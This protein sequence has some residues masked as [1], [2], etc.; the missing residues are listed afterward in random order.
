LTVALALVSLTAHA[1]QPAAAH[2]AA[3]TRYCTT[4]HNAKLKVAG[5]VLNPAQAATP[6][7]DAETWEKV[8][9][10]LRSG[11]MPPAGSSRPDAATYAATAAFLEAGLDRAALANPNP[12][13]LPLLHRLTRTEYQNAIRDLL[14]IEALP[15]EMDYPI[16]LPADNASSGFDNIADLLFMSPT[17]MERYLDAARKISRLAIGDPEAPMMAS[18]YRLSAEHWQDARVDDLPFGTRGGMV[19]RSEF[20]L[21]GEYL[22]KIDVAVGG[23]E[24]HQLEILIDG[25]H[26]QSAIVGGGGGRGAAGKPIEIRVPIA[27]GQHLIGVTFIER[28]QARDEAVLRPR[29]RSRGTMPAI[30][31]VHLSGPYNP[32]IAAAATKPTPSRQRIFDCTPATNADELSCAGRILKTLIRRAYRHPATRGDLQDLMPFYTEGRK[33][34]FDQGVQKAIERL[35]VSPQFLFRIEHEPATAKPGTSYRISNLELASR[36]SFALWSSI[37]DEELLQVAINGKLSNP[38]I[39]EQQTRRMLAD[40]R[41]NSLVNNFATQW[42]FLRDVDVKEP[43]EILF[44]HFDETLRQGFRR[45]TEMFLESVQRDNRSVLDL[46]SAN[47]TYLNERL[48]QHYGV[49]N[50]SGS[51]FRRV[52]FPAGSPRGGLLGQGSVLMLTSY[53]IR[54]SPVVRGK[55][56]LENLLNAAPPPPPPNVPALKTEAEQTGKPLTIREAM[57]Q[58][59]A[60]PACAGCHARMDPI[61][62]ALENFD[63]IGHWRDRENDQPINVD[64]VLPD[65]TKIEGVSGLKRAL[66]A[67]PEEFVSTFVEKL[68]M[69]AL[70]RNVQYYDAPAIR[71][72]VRA[73]K[74]GNYKFND[75]VVGVVKSAPFQMRQAQGNV[76]TASK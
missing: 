4:C 44:P 15:K 6:A 30:A 59:R 73:A 37:P 1:Q 3:L 76:Q 12:G 53:A 26:A 49:P 33:Q 47:Y 48:A 9:R 36:L 28:N 63:A 20:P 31:N 21:S 46:L 18:L 70:G 61:G 17:V 34:S 39:L 32:A 75:L 40:P 2:A 7:A 72:I 42:L 16:L 52:E 43:D 25:E 13:K 5:F 74:P 35:L 69:Y 55:W 22:L 65:G 62:F 51:Y 57:V 50:V 67:Q 29:M 68:M 23:R 41:S 56:V 10:K 54:T 38:I 71:S 14:A 58:H 60:A 8:V 24:Q 64:G 66:L 45:E 27:A 11:S 19:I